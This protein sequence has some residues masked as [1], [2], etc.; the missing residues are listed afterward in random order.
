MAKRDQI[1]SE[2]NQFNRKR[3]Q[4]WRESNQIDNER[5]QF[6]TERPADTVEHALSMTNLINLNG[7]DQNFM[8]VCYLVMLA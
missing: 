8:L 2:S 3:N 4:Y 7:L 6:F 5:N 1:A